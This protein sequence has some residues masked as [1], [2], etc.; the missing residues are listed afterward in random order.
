MVDSQKVPLKRT[1]LR[2]KENR[3]QRLGSYGPFQRSAP[4]QQGVWD[5]M[6]RVRPCLGTTLDRR[7]PE[8]RSTSG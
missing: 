5:K 4:L 1:R 7:L 3:E 6:M 2:T 8:E